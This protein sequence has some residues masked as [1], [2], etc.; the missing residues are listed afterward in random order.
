MVGLRP[1]SA[2]TVLHDGAVVAHGPNPE[3][4]DG[5]LDLGSPEACRGAAT[6]KPLQAPPG[7]DLVVRSLP[8]WLR[9]R[10]ATAPQPRPTPR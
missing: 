1:P 4:A 6:L 5:W 8:R 2:G 10:S 7:M 9:S 3:K